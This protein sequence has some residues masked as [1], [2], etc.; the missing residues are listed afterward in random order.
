MIG[1]KQMSTRMPAGTWV[2]EK[3]ILHILC[4]LGAESL[5]DPWGGKG[6]ETGKGLD[7]E[8]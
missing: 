7:K 1:T 6:V 2:P 5:A 8:G 3:I 4:S